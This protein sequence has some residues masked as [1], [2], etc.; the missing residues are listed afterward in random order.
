LWELIR[1]DVEKNQLIVGFG[2][3]TLTNTFMVQDLH[4]IGEAPSANFACEVRVR[5][6]GKLLHATLQKE[7][8]D[9]WTVQLSA[10]SR[11]IASGQSAVIYVGRTCMGGGIIQ[12]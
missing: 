9:G 12:D 3:E 1:K 5:H 8:N 10:P 7:H 6:G 4:W 2:T 11:G